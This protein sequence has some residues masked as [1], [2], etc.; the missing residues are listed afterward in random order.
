MRCFWH[1]L[2]RK[3]KRVDSDRGEELK[4]CLEERILGLSLDNNTKK[5]DDDNE[6]IG[7]SIY[8]MLALC[9]ILR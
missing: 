2:Y 8:L 6:R 3:V 7:T 1:D 9:Q 4:S 5:I